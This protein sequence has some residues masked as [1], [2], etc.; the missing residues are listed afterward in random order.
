MK[1]ERTLNSI[2]LYFVAVFFVCLSFLDHTAVF[3]PTLCSRIASGGL[4]GPIHVLGIKPRLNTCKTNCTAAA[5]A[6][7]PFFLSFH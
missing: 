2:N 7:M 4:E 5:L 6:L 1:H 3:M